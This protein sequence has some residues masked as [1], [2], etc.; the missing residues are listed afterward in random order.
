[1]TSF[2]TLLWSFLVLTFISFG[3][4]RHGLGHG[5][6]CSLSNNCRSDL[7]CLSGRCACR[8][9]RHQTYD[10]TLDICVSL[11]FGPCTE[12]VDGKTV[13]I[14]C[15]ANAECRNETG[16]PECA[17]RSGTQRMG[18]N[19]RASFGEPCT[20]NGDCFNPSIF[21]DNPVICVNE[22]C[23]CANLE[24]FEEATGRCLGLV[25]AMCG[26]GY[27]C[28]EGA[29]CERFDTFDGTCRCISSFTA[30]PERRCSLFQQCPR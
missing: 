3:E 7:I 12:T 10:M 1:M 22:R 29:A 27:V 28:V 23:G 6:I 16:F 11:L 13:D 20:V 8:Y 26:T 4:C 15:V 19:C 17:C 30:T 9:P 5:E 25:G 14:P 18:R 24:T 2:K 21:S